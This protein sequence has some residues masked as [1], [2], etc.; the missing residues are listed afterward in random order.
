[1]HL[2]S[3]GLSELPWLEVYDYQAPQSTMKE[4]QH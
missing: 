4:K 1:M 3:I 2:I